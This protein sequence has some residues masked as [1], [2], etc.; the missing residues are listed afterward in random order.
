MKSSEPV[1]VVTGGASGIGR[2]IALRLLAAGMRVVVGD[3]NAANGAR[4]LSE[5]GDPGTLRFVVTDVAQEADVAALIDTAVRDF[6]GLDVLVNNA[7][8]GGAFGPLTDIDA[9]DW[10][11]TFAVI[12]R[13]VFLGTKYGARVMISAGT[14]GSIVNMSSAAGLVGGA[15]PLAY[16]A[17][18]AAVVNFTANAAVELAP[19]RIRVNAVCPGLIDTPMVMGRNRAAIVDGLPAVQPWP[20]LGTPEHIAGLVHFLAGPDSEFVTGEAIRADG[21]MLAWG[22]RMESAHDRTGATRRFAGFADGSTG[23]PTVKRALDGPSS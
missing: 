20:D 16:S 22:P 8:V 10:D 15:G 3:V 6:G 23:R 1:A 4:L 2:A 14:G 5:A 18:K 12:G 13:G 11:R 19:H 17:A 21:G 9:A 7:G